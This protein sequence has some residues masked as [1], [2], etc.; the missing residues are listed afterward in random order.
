MPSR[1]QA[2]GLGSDTGTA[3]ELGARVRANL[4]SRNY[5]VTVMELDEVRRASLLHELYDQWWLI[6]SITR[7]V[8]PT[9][10]CMP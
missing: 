6:R 5:E 2:R 1:L 9:Q 4:E 10:F 8:F 3:I 7:F